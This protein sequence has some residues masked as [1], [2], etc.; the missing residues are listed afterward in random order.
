[1]KEVRPANPSAD[2]E[3]LDAMRQQLTR[4]MRSDL[5]VQYAGALRERYAVTTDKR[6]AEQLF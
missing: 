2:K 3:G 4:A 5:L 6:A 1:L